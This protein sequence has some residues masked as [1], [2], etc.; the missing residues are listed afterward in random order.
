MVTISVVSSKLV[1]PVFIIGVPGWFAVIAAV[2][3][4]KIELPPVI[5]KV[6]FVLL[7]L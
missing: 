3:E 2:A 5:S 4:N 6:F 7:F 1:T